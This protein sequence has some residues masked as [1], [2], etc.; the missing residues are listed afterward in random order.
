MLRNKRTSCCA[1]SVRYGC[2]LNNLAQ[3]MASVDEKFRIRIESAFQEWRDTIVHAL[4]RGK[5][6]GSVRNNVDARKAAIFIT[7]LIEGAVGS[8]KNARDPSIVTSAIETLELFVQT[9]RP[10]VSLRGGT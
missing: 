7:S 4:E 5:T 1:S 8:A 9:L 10:N 3:E 2:A 6:N